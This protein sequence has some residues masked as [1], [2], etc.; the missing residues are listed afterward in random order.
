MV[1]KIKL[2]KWRNLET[3]ISKE[4]V[5]ILPVLNRMRKKLRNQ[6]FILKRHQAAQEWIRHQANRV[7][8]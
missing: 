4:H 8:L 6:R 2:S 5:L 3:P 1:W 7:K